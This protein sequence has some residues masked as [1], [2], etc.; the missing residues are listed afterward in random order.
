MWKIINM[1][2]YTNFQ[3]W[4][5]NNEEENSEKSQENENNVFF[6]PTASIAGMQINNNN[7]KY[8]RSYIYN[9]R[10]QQFSWFKYNRYFIVG[11]R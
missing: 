5:N 7:G 6:A 4:N 1:D 2:K 9:C 8:Y 11:F 10:R 3:Y